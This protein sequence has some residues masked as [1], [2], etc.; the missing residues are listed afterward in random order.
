[1]SIL[2]WLGLSGHHRAAPDSDNE[3]AA[4]KDIAQRLEGLDPEHAQRLAAFAMVLA[5]AARADLE[6]ASVELD[7]MV[8]VLADESGLSRDQAQLVVEMASHRN[9]LR[10]AS[11]DYLATREY[12]RHTDH[13]GAIS[14]LRSLFAV[15]AADD[16]ISLI[17]EEELRQVA[18]E[19]G[20]EH[21]EYTA[22]RAEFADRREVLRGLPRSPRADGA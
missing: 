12:R 7:K 9:E 17:E 16:S 5:R 1:M 20:L 15:T 8:E 22:I 4:I 11:E 3:S 19:L 14:L 2:S 21:A 18:S 13:E 6:I 10:G